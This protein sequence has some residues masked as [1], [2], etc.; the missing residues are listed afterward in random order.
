MTTPKGKS[1][2]DQVSIHPAAELFPPMSAEELKAL[3]EDIKKNRLRHSIV[4]WGGRGNVPDQLLDGRNRL[5][6]M[7]ALGI[8]KVNKGALY[9]KSPDGWS[10]VL[11]Q[12][13]PR[14]VD[15][16]E[17]VLSA[18]IHRRHLTSAQRIELLEKV[19]KAN[20]H[21]SSRRAAKLACVSPTTGTKTRARL[22]ASGDVSTVDTSIDTRGRKQPAKKNGK[23]PAKKKRRDVD[24]FLAE[25]RAREAKDAVATADVDSTVPMKDARPITKDAIADAVGSDDEAKKVAVFSPADDLVD[26][27][28]RLVEQMNGRQRDRFKAALK[29]KYPELLDPLEIPA[30]LRRT[31]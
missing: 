18:N 12:H 11:T 5:E 15:P 19:L 22:E 1:W 7:E 8:L 4:L 23:Q 17:Y 20:P 16:Y 27:A 10:P 31:A 25:K 2:R 13:L 14:K 21:M 3:G 29:E 6:A 26:H 28:L 9:Y 30:G 24:D